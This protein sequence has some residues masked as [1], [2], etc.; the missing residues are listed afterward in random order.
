MRATEQQAADTE[1]AQHQSGCVVPRLVHVQWLN[2]GQRQRP[3]MVKWSE[4]ADAGTLPSHWTQK[5][6]DEAQKTGGFLARL[7]EFGRL[8]AL[9]V[10]TLL[11]L[12]P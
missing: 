5:E 7:R 8:Q 9:A 6:A 3:M 1:K 2:E 4:G 11:C 12:T 10:R